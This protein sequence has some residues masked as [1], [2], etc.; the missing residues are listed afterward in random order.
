MGSRVKLDSEHIFECFLEL[1]KTDED[2]EPSVLKSYPEDY[3]E[4]NNGK[5]KL[6]P[7]FTFPCKLEVT[8]VQHYSFALTN[9]DATLTFGFCRIAP[10]GKTQVRYILSQSFFGI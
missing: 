1:V 7:E 10:K 8:T 4:T 9:Q 2:S 5:F 6:V 3:K